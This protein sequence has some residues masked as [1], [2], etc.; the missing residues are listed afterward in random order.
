M[1]RASRWGTSC[2]A[3]S[4]RAS[5]ALAAVIA[6]LAIAGGLCIFLYWGASGSQEPRGS[7]PAAAETSPAVQEASPVGPPA[8]KGASE[9][10][11]L[12]GSENSERKSEEPRPPGGSVAGMVRVAGKNEPAPGVEVVARREAPEEKGIFVERFNVP[13]RDP[14][15]SYAPSMADG[16]YRIDGLSPGE[17]RIFALRAGTDYVSIPAEDGKRIAISSDL[18]NLTVDIEVTA[19]GV[20]HG[21]VTGSDGKPVQEAK[22]QAI[23]PDV[24]ESLLDPDSGFLGVE[25]VTTKEDGLYRIAGL[26][27]EK[28]YAVIAAAKGK[29]K[30]ASDELGFT[31]E[32]RVIELD[33]VLLR[34]SVVSGWVVGANGERAA[35]ADVRI[36]D[37]EPRN[38][39][40]SEPLR[41]AT[42]DA[43]GAFRL[44]GLGAGKY[45]LTASLKEASSRLETLKL[46]GEGDAE[47][48]ELVL[49]SHAAGAADLEG[50]VADDLGKAVAKAE[51]KLAGLVPE[52]GPYTAAEESREDGA[53]TFQK[54][55]G[56]IFNLNV[57]KEGYAPWTR[58]GVG[59]GSS[60]VDVVLLRVSRVKG[61]VISGTS[62][63]PVEGALVRLSLVSENGVDFSRLMA[64][65][66]SGGAPTA[67]SGPD[68]AFVLEK[69]SP[70]KARL[71][72][73]ASGFGPGISAEL[74]VPP[75]EETGGIKVA[76]PAGGGVSGRVVAP[77]GKPMADATVRAAEVTG[78]AMESQLRRILPMFLPGSSGQSVKTEADGTFKLEHLPEGKI[79]LAAS[80][81]DFGPSADLEIELGPDQ[82][83]DRV[84]LRLR[85]PGTVRVR[86]HEKG[87]PISG[88]MVQV[89]GSGPMKMGNLDGEGKAS[90]GGLAPGDYLVQLLDV[91]KMM[92]GQGLGLKQKAAAVGEGQTVDVEFAFGVGA[93][94][95]GTV[96]GEVPG[97]MKMV[98]LRRAEAPRSEEH[99]ITD[100]TSSIRDVE[101]DAG[102]AFISSDGTYSI[103]DV[104]DGEFILQV[105]RMPSDFSKIAELKPEEQ[106]PLYSEKIKVE[107][108]KD[109]E[110]DIAIPEGK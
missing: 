63:E 106:K 78:N 105:P 32:E 13:K 34:G 2:G 7:E 5:S 53:F 12:S 71:R 43:T 48:L 93:T 44:D 41:A 100:F 84:E 72:A 83:V 33:F 52:K 40:L 110:R 26:P 4:G 94:V 64:G 81:V 39:F 20:F 17:Y 35:G 79:V 89:M 96:K 76:L 67:K 57:N 29:T 8:V 66:L 46:D 77:D 45:N 14:G 24:F 98:L 75:G 6:T 87:K 9:S 88:L 27:L 30:T 49:D 68:G 16:R 11:P 61:V 104:P 38:L 1:G 82:A 73:E 59:A 23:P 99:K 97:A 85:A 62:G 22:V 69:V 103:P 74:D 56:G 36:V 101:N 21:K 102:M 70:G 92:S 107:G 31:E 25:E 47:N 18:E 19:G 95:K 55:P 51:V 10:V 28:S 90:F 80:H 108:G 15:D 86:A 50:R 109:V 37:T 58:A 3:D 54:V 65:E 60:P 91:A 42:T